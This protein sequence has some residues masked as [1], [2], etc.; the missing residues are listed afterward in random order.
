MTDGHT[1]QGITPPLGEALSSALMYTFLFS[2]T[3]QPTLTQVM[4]CN[5][6]SS[7]NT[8]DF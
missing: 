1:H 7:K 8:V 5:L 4:I 6:E 3:D 2:S